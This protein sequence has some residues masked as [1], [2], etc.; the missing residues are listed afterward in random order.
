[1]LTGNETL[2]I[3]IITYI[4]SGR[5]AN[6]AERHEQLFRITNA[7]IRSGR[8]ANPAE[9]IA[10]PAERHPAERRP[11]GGCYFSTLRDL[12]LLVLM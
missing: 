12:A 6:P 2:G 11:N 4:R 9:R 7:Y 3:R 5:I 1:L 10:N 8:I